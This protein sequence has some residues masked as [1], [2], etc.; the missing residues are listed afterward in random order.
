MTDY[1]R[2][3][4]KV[5]LAVLSGREDETTLLERELATLGVPMDP[6]YNVPVSRPNRHEIRLLAEEAIFEALYPEDDY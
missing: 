3:R 6:R 2:E 5:A 4:V 1:Q